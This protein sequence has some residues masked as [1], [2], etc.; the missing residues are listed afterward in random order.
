MSLLYRTVILVGILPLN[1]SQPANDDTSER[2]NK[3]ASKEKRQVRSDIHGDPLPVG[4]IARMGTVRLRQ[5]YPHVLFSPDGKTLI[6]VGVDNTLRTWDASTGKYLR[7]QRLEGTQDLDMSA[8]T[9]APDGRNVVVWKSGRKS[10]LV[11]TVP[12]GKKLGSLPVAEGQ[13]Y[14]IGLAPGGKTVAAAI[15]GPGTH[16]IRLWDVA[17]GAERLLLEHKTH[18]ENLTFSPDGKFL[19]A[20]GRDALRVWDVST[21]KLLQQVSAEAWCLV[22]SPD[23]K[24]I[25]SGNMDGT[26]QLWD[27][28]TGKE[29]A[30]LKAKLP[31]DI[32]CLA[33][34]PDGQ[35]LAAG[36]QAGLRLWDLVGRKE[37]YQ[38]PDRMVYE[39]V[40]APNS[41]VL[42]ASGG[43]NIRLWD[44]TTGKQLLHR[45]GH[46]DQ[47]DSIVVSS[48]GK[49]LVSTSYSDGTLCFWDAKTGELLHQPP[50]PDIAGRN[51]GLS[52]DG[53][54]AASGFHDSALHLWETNTGKELRRFPI[55]Q[56]DAQGERPFVD[57]L[58]LSPDGKRLVA[59]T[60]V[61]DSNS[62]INIWDTSTGKL[63]NRR[64]FGG[65]FSSFTPDAS[66]V[67]VQ[68]PEGLFIHDVNTGRQL[69]T[70]PGIVNS[71]QIA[72][73]S[74]GKLLAVPLAGTQINSLP[75]PGF[76][77]IKVASGKEM[78]RVDSGQV[79][80]LAFSRDAQML[81]TSDH[82]VV[83][84]W[85]IL[86]G[87]EIFRRPR[88][89]SLPG[90]PAQADVTSLAFFPDGSG[91][92]TGMTDGTILIWDLA[93]ETTV[94][95]ELGLKEIEG[96]WADLA[97]NDASKAYHA[98][99]ILAASPAESLPYL[100]GHLQPAEEIDLKRVERLIADLDSER[101]GVRDS[102][103]KELAKVTWEFESAIRRALERK[104]SLEVRRRLEAL[105]AA[106]Q[107]VPRAPTLRT[108]RA[109]QVLERIGIL[110]AR[111]LLR[112]LANGPP[113]ARLT[114]EAKASLERVTKQPQAAP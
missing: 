75:R 38:L 97:G 106:P 7:G 67:T 31:H 41:K 61:D 92:A 21:D 6:S 96:L 32:Q 89:E 19:G 13:L 2:E 109:I 18:D 103:A 51:A 17:T 94:A 76:S 34:S 43:S 99:R 12:A 101:F 86:T 69:V 23:S 74:D 73:S 70:I 36:G 16:S 113:D 102:A 84:L 46:N 111:E 24:K 53:K 4:A 87:K 71:F 50:G 22:F 68:T 15:N 95:K 48:D 3:L 9:L 65:P 81:A 37:V 14:R 114:Q 82:H 33:F 110:E 66:G 20:A 56:L 85:E 62:Q 100:R 8:I 77:I 28:A 40:F 1:W 44:V 10:M 91:L 83:R 88:H 45:S 105:L 27:V 104:L 112:K 79:H 63:L 47:V 5:T 59:I 52:A 39:L 58:Q 54:L 98:I 72:F 64:K 42:A 55:Q 78:L 60:R 93:P 26:V 108:L 57:F 49:V 25:A 30:T 80:S 35:V 29:V 107:E 90:I 11:F